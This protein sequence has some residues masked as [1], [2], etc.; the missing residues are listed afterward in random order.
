MHFQ[1]IFY[2]LSWIFA[3]LRDILKG[4]SE[5]ACFMKNQDK[6]CDNALI[7]INGCMFLWFIPRQFLQQ[8]TVRV[9]KDLQCKVMLAGGYFHLRRIGA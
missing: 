2:C 7:K 8:I 4:R 1:T 9:V 6:L 3:P 5:F